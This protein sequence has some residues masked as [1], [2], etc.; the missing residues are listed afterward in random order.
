MHIRARAR[1]LV[2][3]FKFPAPARFKTPA[4]SSFAQIIS[5]CLPNDP[6]LRH[7]YVTHS[8]GKK[9]QPTTTKVQK[10]YKYN[11]R[12]RKVSNCNESVPPVAAGQC[13]RGERTT[14]T[15]G[16]CALGPRGSGPSVSLS[17]SLTHSLSP[18][19]WSARSTRA[20]AAWTHLRAGPRRSERERG[21][22]RGGARGARVYSEGKSGRNGLKSGECA[23][24]KVEREK[25]NAKS[26]RSDFR[27]GLSIYMWKVGGLIVWLCV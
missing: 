4:H 17:R 6:E 21:A 16:G 3:Y 1:A 7:I 11:N 27:S 9:K 26:G 12:G 22:A 20:R 2:D 15:A 14:E 8:T 18:S 23:C 24:V 13:T 25:E 5:S 10:S 19:A